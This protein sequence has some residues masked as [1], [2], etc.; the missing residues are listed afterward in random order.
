MTSPP[1][2]HAEV[3]PCS[4]AGHD[5]LSALSAQACTHIRTR[6]HTHQHARMHASPLPTKPNPTTHA[7]T[8][9]RTHTHT[10]APARAACPPARTCTCSHTHTRT[11]THTHTWKFFSPQPGRCA[12]HCTSVLQWARMGSGAHCSTMRSMASRRICEPGAGGVG[13]VRG[14][15]G[16][17]QGKACPAYPG[18]RLGFRGRHAQPTLGSGWGSGRSLGTAGQAEL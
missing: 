5:H 16:R 9:A 4:Q 14:Q 15:G 13:R 2:L 6:P 11:R 10:P 1:P 17:V 18:F 3:P 8:P 12:M 7:N